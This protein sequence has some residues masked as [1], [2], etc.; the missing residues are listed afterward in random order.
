MFMTRLYRRKAQLRRTYRASRSLGRPCALENGLGGCRIRLGRATIGEMIIAAST[1][2]IVKVVISAC[3][4][5]AIFA[6][7]VVLARETRKYEERQWIRRKKYDT[8]L[9]RWQEIAPPLND[10]LCFFML[11]GHFREVTP[12]GAIKRK[13]QLDRAVYANQNIFG[14]TFLSAYGR[15]MSLCFKT[16][17]GG[18]G[19]DAKIRASVVNQRAERGSTW[20]DSWAGLFVSA[21]DVPPPS[22][23]IDA[24]NHVI[25]TYDEL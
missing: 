10:L 16:Y 7:G 19:A 17:A 9:E 21:K 15:F 22:D 14:P 5:I 4:P 12:P 8:R 18:V 23:V 3:I 24:Y 2:E 20:D 25:E 6:A 13:R 11:V 1:L